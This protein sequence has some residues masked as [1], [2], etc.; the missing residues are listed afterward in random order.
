MK[1]IK[2]IILLTFGLVNFSYSQIDTTDYSRQ[3]EF[4]LTD[5]T[6][7]QGQTHKIFDI[8]FS[9]KD[10]V[11][12]VVDNKSLDSIAKLFLKLKIKQV[13]LTYYHSWADYN[14]RI[15][16]AEKA[17]A[18]KKYLIK[19]GMKNSHITIS[20]LFIPT[21]DFKVPESAKIKDEYIGFYIKTI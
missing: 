4:K 9:K 14:A 2:Y 17:A 11:T 7:S 18:I 5:K 12:K 3:T 10:S 8:S 21:K 16:S 19:R 1:K 15:E 20:I 13:V 6:L